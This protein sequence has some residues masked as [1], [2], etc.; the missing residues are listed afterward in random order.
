MRIAMGI[1]GEVVGDPMTPPEIV[2]D[3]RRAEA[4]GFP[5]AWCVHFSRGVDALNVLR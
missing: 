1:G 3:A 2:E 4:D 5:S